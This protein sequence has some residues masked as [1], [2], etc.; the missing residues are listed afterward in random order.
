MEKTK[1]FEEN[2]VFIISSM[3]LVALVAGMY[4]LKNVSAKNITPEETT[5]T[6]KTKAVLSSPAR[7][8][9]ATTN[10][11]VATPQPQPAVVNPAVP[12]PT[13]IPPTTNRSH[14]GDDSSYVE[15][16]DD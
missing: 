10:A 13:I 1:F 16:N 14:S 3:V 9:A 2:T 15:W 11:V 7:T 4:Y 8:A 5:L 12:K 6:P